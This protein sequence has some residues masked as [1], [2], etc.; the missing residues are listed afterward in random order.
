[1]TSLGGIE[2]AVDAWGA[3]AV[4]SG[5]QKCLSA[6]PGVSPLTF[7]E[8]AQGRL[9]ARNRP[10]ASWFLD[11]SLVMGYWG[12]GA[13]R[14][15]HH[16][17]PVNALYGVHEALV[18]LA[19]EGLQAAWA[20][21]RRNHLALRAG[22]EALGLEFVVAEA[23]RLPQLNT[24]RIPEGVDDALVRRRL[25]EQYGLEIGAGLGALAKRVWRIGLMGQS[26]TP[27]HVYLCLSALEQVLLEL[28]V[29]LE[30]GRAV[31]AARASYEAA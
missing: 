12:D 30:A 3:D 19:E 10:V 31:A 27:R 29:R 5:T 21:H 25:L 28:G 26:S 23:D 17:A 24:V 14:T 9:R 16:T 7:S 8:R 20:R 1:V 6:P 18:M 2:V 22:I 11:L 4:Y 13:T 15:Y